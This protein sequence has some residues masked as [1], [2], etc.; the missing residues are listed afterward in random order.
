[1]RARLR[2]ESGLALLPALILTLVM[3]SFGFAILGGIDTQQSGSKRERTRESSF[4]IAEAAL[5]AQA[6]QLARSWPTGAGAPGSCDPSSTSTYCAEP[7][8]VGGGYTAGDYASSCPGSPS[9]PLWQ[10]TVRDNVVGQQHWSTTVNSQ[11]AYDANGDNSVWVRST[12]TVQCHTVGVVALASRGVIP[13]DFPNNVLRANFFQ[14]SNQGRKVIIDT[15]GAYAQPPSARPGP[16]AQPAGISVRCSGLS[17]GQC[18]NYNASKG[19]VQPPAIQTDSGGSPSALSLAQLQALERQARAA[20]TFYDTGTC[21]TTAQLTS[22]AGAPVYVK[23]PC[24]IVVGNNSVINSATGP[25]ALIIE[26]GT[27]SI[28][29]NATFY[30]LL[31]VVNKQ[32]FAGV[33]VTI[34]GNAVIQGVVSVDGAGGVLAGSSKTNLV[35]DARAVSLLRGDT[36]ASLRKDTFRVLPSNTPQ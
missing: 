2:D 9:T 35:Y 11:P 33:V 25:G 34:S 5:N 10:T 24:D 18:K 29:G 1:M 27:F 8:A 3:L 17:D 19:Q 16:A 14:T 21:P 4:N 6:V 36:G 12:G 32:N 26:N 30:G 28:G 13:M 31:Y 22:T 7:S 20:G 23:G 15:L